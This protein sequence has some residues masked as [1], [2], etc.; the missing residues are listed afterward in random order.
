LKGLRRKHEQFRQ[1]GAQ[2][3]TVSADPASELEEY[4]KAHSIPFIML[5]DSAKTVIKEYGI[6]NPAERGGIAIPAIFIIDESGTIRYARLER[7]VLRARNKTL[8]KEIKS[9]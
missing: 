3:V 6:Y 5:S 2:I 4:R 8:L 1:A 9:M 7:T